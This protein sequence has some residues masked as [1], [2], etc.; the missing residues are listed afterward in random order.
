M[1]SDNIPNESLVETSRAGAT[2]ALADVH[3][4]A[5][6]MPSA[7]LASLAQKPAYGAL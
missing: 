5:L 2:L 7:V 3:G 4:L 6:R 1:K